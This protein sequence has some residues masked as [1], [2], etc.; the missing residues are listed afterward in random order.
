MA[1]VAAVEVEQEDGVAEIAVQALLVV[2]QV[3]VDVQ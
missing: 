1:V 2:V 3:Q